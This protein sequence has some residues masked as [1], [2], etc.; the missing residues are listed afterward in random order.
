MLNLK[1]YKIIDEKQ[2]ID[3]LFNEL[4]S[5]LA[6]YPNNRVDFEFDKDDVWYCDGEEFERTEFAIYYGSNWD[7]DDE[8]LVKSIRVEDG[9]LFFECVHACELEE[10]VYVWPNKLYNRTQDTE[11]LID[12]LEFFIDILKN[13]FGWSLGHP[14][15]MVI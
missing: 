11:F 5:L 7:D 4:K 10:V 15:F 3:E 2:K 14:N 8:L 1:N 12:A 6:N 13:K 9:E